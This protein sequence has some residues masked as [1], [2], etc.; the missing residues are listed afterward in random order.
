MLSLR[1]QELKKC[2]DNL[3]APEYAVRELSFE[4]LTGYL[5]GE[6]VE[7][8]YAELTA[9]G[10]SQSYYWLVRYLTAA[11]TDKA[12]SFLLKIAEDPRPAIRDEACRGI[13][14][15]SAEKKAN[16]CIELLKSSWEDVVLFS[17]EQLGEMALPRAAVPLMEALER[18]SNDA[19]C[20]AIVRSIG[21]IHDLR[22]IKSLQKLAL[23]SDGSVQEAAFQALAKYSVSLNRWFL[24]KCLYSSEP[25]TRQITY[26]VILH[27]KSRRWEPLITEALRQEKNIDLKINVLSF[28]RNVRT[29]HFFDLLF[30]MAVKDASGQIRMMAESSLR[31]I[32]TGQVRR[33][34]IQ[35]SRHSDHAAAAMA[36]RLLGN[37]ASANNEKVLMRHSIDTRSA[38]KQ[39]AA[40]EA[41]GRISSKSARSFLIRL[42]QSDGRFAGAAACALMESFEG[43]PLNVVEDLIQED[44]TVV[45]EIVFRFLLRLEKKGSLPLPI[46]KRIQLETGA[47]N[48]FLRYLAI[49]CCGRHCP[50]GLMILLQAAMEDVDDSIRESCLLAVVRSISKNPGRLLEIVDT[51]SLRPG[52][53]SLF[54]FVL[55]RVLVGDPVVMGSFVKK[56]H[57]HVSEGRLP[58]GEDGDSNTAREMWKTLLA[59]S[60]ARERTVF[61]TMLAET[62]WDEAQRLFLM[63]IINQAPPHHAGNLPVQFMTASYD[64]ASRDL[65]LQYLQFLA[66]EHI[67]SPE[68]VQMIQRELAGKE[69]DAVRRQALKTTAEWLLP[70]SLGGGQ[71]EHPHE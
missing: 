59:R 29:S 18:H 37:F 11:E 4:C 5:R 70:E 62:G 38:A 67:R 9:L 7:W 50:D 56:V 65:R 24:R 26:A 6:D 42:A 40:I 25:K 1:E 12:S 41:L 27:Q 61:L 13:K 16:L 39:L 53:N 58:S 3:L 60:A 64:Q 22:A 47:K 36:I 71:K 48:P 17:A 44:N 19:V 8:V 57:D 34:L 21:K 2:L 15:I 28:I 46:L 30:E 10:D 63:E 32:R 31:K 23:R 33:W 20:A 45:I 51:A 43:V 49:R 54:A 14:R 52:M 68:A 55:D 35:K 66:R 69:D